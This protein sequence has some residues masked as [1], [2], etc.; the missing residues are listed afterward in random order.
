MQLYAW[1][2]DPVRVAFVV[3]LSFDRDQQ[4]AGKVGR[5]WYKPPIFA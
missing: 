5:S 1:Q 4:Y 3:A 2:T